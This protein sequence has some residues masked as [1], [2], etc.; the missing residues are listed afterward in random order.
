[1]PSAV[2]A[3]RPARCDQSASARVASGIEAKG[4]SKA[5]PIQRATWSSRSIAAGSWAAVRFAISTWGSSA[6]Q[7]APCG[8]PV[9]P[10]SGPASPWTA[11]S[12]A[13]ASAR[14]PHRLTQAISSRASASSASISR[15]IAAS[16]RG[17]ASRHNASVSGFV[18]V[19]TKGSI[20]WV[21]ASRPEASVTGRGQP[22]VSAG[23][24]IAR[25]GSIRASRRLTL[26]RCSGTPITA[27]RVTSAP[28][29]AV[30]GMATKGKGGWSSGR[31]CPT[32]SRWSSIGRV[33]GTSAAMAFP[34][35][36]TA[37]PPRATTTCA[38]WAVR[39]PWATRSVSGS[40]GTAK[41]TTSQPCARNPS[42][43]QAA[44]SG[45]RPWTSSTRCPSPTTRAAAL[46]ACPLP[47]RISAAE[48]KAK[49]ATIRPSDP[50][51]RCRYAVPRRP[52]FRRYARS[53]GG[54]SVRVP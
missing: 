3:G 35:S 54:R 33:A 45:L 1:M 8:A 6:P 44:R 40:R 14:P 19:Q 47:N 41:P 34:A 28:V 7:I 13:L 51:R 36:M 42:A 11:P 17:I 16:P 21:T 31:P 38:P 24:T 12:P 32:T 5:A 50:Q 43:S 27:L 49:G 9:S 2:S 48:A 39:M 18:R 25:R 4:V 46:A 10:P 15:R 30:V 52:R 29:P 37:P 53:P 26:R 20:T 22:S 23:S